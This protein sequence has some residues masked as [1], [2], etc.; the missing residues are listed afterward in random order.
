MGLQRIGHDWAT[1]QTN[2]NSAQ[3]AGVVF[4]SGP[5]FP[6]CKT[7]ESGYKSSSLNIYEPLFFVLYDRYVVSLDVLSVYLWVV[8][9]L[10]SRWSSGHFPSEDIN[11]VIASASAVNLSH[12]RLRACSVTQSCPTLYDPMDYSP[13]GS[14]VHGFSRQEYWSGLPF[15]SPGDLPDP[16]LLYCRQLLYHL[17]HQGSL[18]HL[19]GSR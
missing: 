17:S 16:G 2:G 9:L 19:G 8:L 18:I 3:R 6:L 13:P 11:L 15:P 5:Q 12:N 4:F 7:T 10:S 1:E 14:S